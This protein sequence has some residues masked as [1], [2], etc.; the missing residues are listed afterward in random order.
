MRHCCQ[1]EADEIYYLEDT[2]LLSERKLSI[3]FCPI[4]NKPVAELFEVS[5]TGSIERNRYSG[6]KANE[7]LIE[8]KSQIK[9]SLRQ[10]NYMK[11]RSK[12]Y[13]WKYGINKSVKVNGKECLKQYA[14]DFYGNKE[15]IKVLS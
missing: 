4:C 6:I 15:L 8:L 5:F 10:C 3:G 14:K 11:F 2:A 1:F 13:G 9:Y 12:P 7:K